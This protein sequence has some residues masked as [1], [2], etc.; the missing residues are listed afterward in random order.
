MRLADRNRHR[1]GFFRNADGG[2][3]PG[4]PLR[5]EQRVGGDRQK[6]GRRRD[7]I[8]LNHHRAIMQRRSR[9]ED[10]NEQVVAEERGWRP[11]VG[12]SLPG[13]LTQYVESNG[14]GGFKDIL[15]WHPGSRILDVGSGWGAISA[16]LAREYTVISLEGVE[17]RAR[18][19]ALRA[20]QD[21]LANLYSV[22]AVLPF[23]RLGA[24]QFDGIVLNGVLEWVGV[25]QPSIN[26][27]TAQVEFLREMR[28]LLRPGGSVYLAIENR[29]GWPE[30]RG[31]I[32][33]SGL[34]YT[35]LLPRF[36]ARWVVAGHSLYRSQANSGYRTYTY[37]LQGYRKLFRAAGLRSR[38][39]WIC[40]SG[41]NQP[42]EILPLQQSAIRY[43]VN[44]HELSR[45]GHWRHWVKHRV[46]QM[47]GQEWLWRTFGSDC[48]FILEPADA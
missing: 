40:P 17:E 45:A 23:L 13:S 47:L 14:R 32:D 38:E 12:Q 11:A 2:A 39:I 1:V 10:G 19:I 25:W 26:P 33:H 20:R 41:Y 22:R 21:R 43:F 7:A 44:R 31:A 16:E 30:L 34:P 48:L 42:H 5:R 27:R 36:L 8:A 6:T 18:F 29:F 4:A 15:P 3:M 9:A 35:S 46:K 24:E 28:R 37:T